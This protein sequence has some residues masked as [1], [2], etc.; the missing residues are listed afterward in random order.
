MNETEFD[1]EYKKKL[2]EKLTKISEDSELALRE[3]L[4]EKGVDTSEMQII[5]RSKF[6]VKYIP[7]VME[8]LF[9]KYGTSQVLMDKPEI[10]NEARKLVEKKFHEELDKQ[11]IRKWKIYYILLHCKIYEELNIEENIKL[12]PFDGLSCN[13]YFEIVDKICSA[14]PASELTEKSLE[15]GKKYIANRH[16]EKIPL[17]LLV[18]ENLDAN[19]EI[20]VY[21]KTNKYANDISLSMSAPTNSSIEI[22]GWIIEGQ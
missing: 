21:E 14:P 8:E 16:R 5:D 1:E 3:T 17:S 9:K 4:E 19:S 2:S 6:M 10:K 22:G 20:E 7:D 13:D 12:I 15:N 18:I 11:K